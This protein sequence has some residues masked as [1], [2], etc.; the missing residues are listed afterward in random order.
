MEKLATEIREML[1]D[2]GMDV[3]GIAPAADW[4]SPQPECRPPAILK[5][6]Q[7]VIV[8]GKEI[9]APIYQAELHALD[10]YAMTSHN[11]YHQLDAAAIAAAG[12]LTRAGYPSIPIG[13]YQPVLMRE[14][15]YWGVV[16]LKHAAVRAG[17]G[18]MGKNT[19]LINERFGNRL[20]LGGVLTTAALPAGRPLAK[21]LCYENCTK[22]VR[23]CPVQALDGKGGINQH[24]CLKNC[25]VHPALSLSFISR[26]FRHSKRVNRQV[27]LFTRTMIST[28]TYSCCTCL[29]SCP[30]FKLGAGGSPG[31]KK[32]K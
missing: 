16:S 4:P 1:E 12:R 18:T 23:N 10:L 20:R 15:D 17:L 31:G 28:Y 19:L 3:V 26:W 21:S 9:P 24:K 2:Q 25:A 27:E 6:C 5:D 13:G 22:C 30:S 11:F 14:G 8:F 7:R 29:T 32:D